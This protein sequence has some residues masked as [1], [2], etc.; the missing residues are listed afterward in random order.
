MIIIRNNMPKIKQVI[1]WTVILSMVLWTVGVP[2]APFINE[3]KAEGGVNMIYLGD[4]NMPVMITATGT[5]VAAVKF[6]IY[7]TGGGTLN[8]LN[9]RLQKDVY[10]NPFTPAAAL[11]DLSYVHASSSGMSLWLDDGDGVFEVNEDTPAGDMQADWTPVD[12][13]TWSAA[14]SSI[15]WS[16]GITYPTKSIIFLAFNAKDF[17]D[18]NQPY[19]FKVQINQ[20]NMHIQD[21]M[22]NNNGYWPS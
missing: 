6:E 15:N 10:E 18:E 20:N 12:D 3:A 19:S 22:I 13:T 14:F 8:N 5:P 16:I 17:S 11:N 21:S 9:V 7:D 2:F 4:N 1:T